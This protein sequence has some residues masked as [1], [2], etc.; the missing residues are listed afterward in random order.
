MEIK[1]PYKVA[2]GS[3]HLFTDGSYTLTTLIEL[4]IVGAYL[5]FY[6]YTEEMKAYVKTRTSQ[7]VRGVYEHIM[8]DRVGKSN[9]TFFNG[10]QATIS[11]ETPWDQRRHRKLKAALEEGRLQYGKSIYK[12]KKRPR[13]AWIRG[14]RSVA[15]CNTQ[16]APRIYLW[17]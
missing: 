1:R 6:E 3:N 9:T 2:I 14:S 8:L 5:A 10:N 12:S 13:Y 4:K 16:L 11:A 17:R 15:L 7:D